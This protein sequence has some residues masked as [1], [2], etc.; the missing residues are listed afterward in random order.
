[1]RYIIE[2]KKGKEVL[3]NS[4]KKSIIYIIKNRFIPNYFLKLVLRFA[5][6]LPAGIDLEVEERVE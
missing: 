4:L 3:R 5:S 6:L 1:L 2:G